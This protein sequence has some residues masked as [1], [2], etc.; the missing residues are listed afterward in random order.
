[1]DSNLLLAVFVAAEG[2]HAFSAFMPSYFTVQ[3]FAR[4]DGDRA[5]LRSGYVPAIAIN[6]LLAGTVAA[7]RK[8]VRPILFM[9]AVV[10]LMIGLYE[11]ALGQ[12]SDERAAEPRE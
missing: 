12:L 9:L 7:L 8:D 1:M 10:A 11:N 2:A 4:G 3:K 6:V 5:R